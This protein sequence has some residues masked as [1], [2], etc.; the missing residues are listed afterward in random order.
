MFPQKFA[1]RCDMPAPQDLL[2]AHH[3]HIQHSGPILSGH[4][5]RLVFQQKK[6][7]GSS[8]LKVEKMQGEA[9]KLIISKLDCK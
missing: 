6:E 1:V 9:Y 2:R 5:G 8:I 3:G 4:K 7:T